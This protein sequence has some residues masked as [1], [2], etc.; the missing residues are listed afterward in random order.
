[1]LFIKFINKH[2]LKIVPFAAFV[3]LF[4]EQFRVNDGLK[5]KY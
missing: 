1:M 2:P 4:S 5:C 3:A